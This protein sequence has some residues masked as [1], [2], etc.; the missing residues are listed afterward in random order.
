MSLSGPVSLSFLSS[1]IYQ[2]EAHVEQLLLDPSVLD[3]LCWSHDLVF[4]NFYGQQIGHTLNLMGV[5]F[6]KFCRN[7]RSS[8]VILNILIFVGV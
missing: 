5:T 8:A 4:L 6:K 1:R 2:D 7:I 3:Q